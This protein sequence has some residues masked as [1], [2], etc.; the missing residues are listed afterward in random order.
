MRLPKETVLHEKEGFDFAACSVYHKIRG[1]MRSLVNLDI[2][3]T[4]S[5]AACKRRYDDNGIRNI[6]IIDFLLDFTAKMILY[7]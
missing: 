1:F 2:Y 3:V 6:N 5:F 7:S 4:G